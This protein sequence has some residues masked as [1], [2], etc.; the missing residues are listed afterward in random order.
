MSIGTHLSFILDDI[1]ESIVQYDVYLYISRK[2]K[3]IGRLQQLPAGWPPNDSIDHLCQKVGKLFIY[4]TT[5]CRFINNS[6]FDP[7]ACLYQL[8]EERSTQR[9]TT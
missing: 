1:Q 2:L 7:Q 3:E 8:L 5:A 9:L 6:I 4:A